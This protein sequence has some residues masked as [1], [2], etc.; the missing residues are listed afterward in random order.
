MND[1]QT[2]PDWDTN[3][4]RP[5]T[6]NIKREN[7]ASVAEALEGAGSRVLSHLS[8]PVNKLTREQARLARVEAHLTGDPVEGEVRTYAGPYTDEDDHRNMW[9]YEQEVPEVAAEGEMVTRGGKEKETR[10]RTDESRQ[11]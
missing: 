10:H 5:E 4:I 3:D 2:K 6:K 7:F 1:R 11:Y 8:S 9:T